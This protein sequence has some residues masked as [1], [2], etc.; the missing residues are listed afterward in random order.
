MSA[1]SIAEKRH[2]RTRL[3][4]SMPG[5]II[6]LEC[7]GLV[8]TAL[9]ADGWTYVV[10]QTKSTKVRYVSPTYAWV[11]K[12]GKHRGAVLHRDKRPESSTGTYHDD[13]QGVPA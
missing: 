10:D 13:C 7:E 4:A 5:H 3:F 12:H 11:Q 8:Y 6:A 2:Q 1:L 9:L